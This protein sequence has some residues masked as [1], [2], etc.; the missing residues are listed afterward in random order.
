MKLQ[1]LVMH[2]NVE[3]YESN[4]EITQCIRLNA[5]WKIYSLP[6]GFLVFLHETT[7]D[8]SWERVL[9]NGTGFKSVA[10]LFDF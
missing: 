9:Y 7:R 8:G 3:I 4:A 1:L 2:L 10:T 6:P 5:I